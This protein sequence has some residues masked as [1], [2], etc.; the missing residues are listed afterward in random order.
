MS[1]DLQDYLKDYEEEGKAR[2]REHSP[3]KARDKDLDNF[4]TN[5]K[6]KKFAALFDRLNNQIIG[7]QQFQKEIDE[8]SD[9]ER[10]YKEYLAQVNDDYHSNDAEMDSYHS[11]GGGGEEIVERLKAAR[12]EELEE[13][14]LQLN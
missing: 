5:Y 6:E 2:S 7:S 1:Q 12:Y 4:R 13:E 9:E 3:A 10:K 8:L 11:G 14:E